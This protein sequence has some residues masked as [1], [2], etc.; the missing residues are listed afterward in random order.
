MNIAYIY[1]WGRSADEAYVYDDGSYKYLRDR[2]VASDDDAA[3]VVCARQ[4]AE[5]HDSEFTAVT[6]GNGDTAWAAARGAAKTVHAEGAMPSL[7]ESDTAKVIA[8]AV[9][10]LG[11]VDVAVIGDNVETAGVAPQV[12]AL[13]GLPFI[14]GVQDFEAVP[15]D[16]G[17]V[18]AHRKI[19]KT[20]QTVRIALPALIGVSAVEQEKN[21]P[22][23]K[24]MLAAKKA[25][26]QTV[27]VDT[28]VMCKV[29]QTACRCPEVHRAH[30]FEGDAHESVAALLA[31]LK[32]DEV[33]PQA[34]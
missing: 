19:D 11:E 3:A 5:A 25:P 14:G 15:G 2:L 6:I 1:K 24:Q 22:S 29:E 34:K 7:D 4:F 21:V 20:V 18:I 30:I 33:L 27:A 17:H 28:P 16:T 26:V 10:E 9:K 31:A 12:A 8:A 13:L 23:I 32:A